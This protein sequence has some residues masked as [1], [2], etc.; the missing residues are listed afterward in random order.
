MA[1][2]Q[3][4]VDRMK[5]KKKPTDSDL[6]DTV[7]CIVML[8]LNNILVPVLQY[9]NTGSGMVSELN[10]TSVFIRI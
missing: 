2:K 8:I 1:L 10:S 3:A 7:Q 5:R 4:T 6:Q 9:S